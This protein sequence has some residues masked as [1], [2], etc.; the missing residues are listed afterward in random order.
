[1]RAAMRFVTLAALIT[2]VCLTFAPRLF[3]GDQFD[4]SD[5]IPEKY[6]EYW[7]KAQEAVSR[8]EYPEESLPLDVGAE[9][10][11]TEAYQPE[12]YVGFDDPTATTN[13]GES[14][15]DEP[16]TPV[17]LSEVPASAVTDVGKAFDK[18]KNALSKIMRA[19][20]WSAAEA[21][22][23]NAKTCPPEDANYNRQVVHKDAE[24][25]AKVTTKDILAW[26]REMVT[27]VANAKHEGKTSGRGIVMSA[28]DQESFDRVLTN[29]RILRTHGSKLPVEIYH[30]RSE[31][32]ELHLAR[33]KVK[34]LE[35][36][37]AKFIELKGL[38]REESQWK[39]FQI[40]ATA[41]QRC[42]FDQILWLDSDSY[43]LRDPEYLFDSPQFKERGVML[44]PDYTKSHPQQ[45]VWRLLGQPCR[46]EFEA[47]SG[48]VLIDRQRHQDVLFLVEYFAMNW[49][50]FYGFMGGDRESFR[51][52]CLALG[53]KWAGP[54]RMMAMAGVDSPGHPGGHWGLEIA[55]IDLEGPPEN[56]HRGGHTMLQADPEGRWLFAHA[57][58]LK[59]KHLSRANEV[60]WARVT[61]VKDDRYSP[62]T[63]YGDI[64]PA[65]GTAG[66]GSAGAAGSERERENPVDS[67][68]AKLGDGIR[69]YV[70]QGS[71]LEVSMWLLPQFREAD[72]ITEEDWARDPDLRD[73]E[74]LYFEMGG[75][76][77][78]A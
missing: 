51:I 35:S 13:H 12:E 17:G 70:E 16:G 62:G 74:K 32:S 69:S 15:D 22:R 34:E 18:Q 55:G 3:Y 21:A 49:K 29:V 48:Q 28:G 58:L 67:H 72:L 65:A 19:P 5:Q 75:Q 41:M 46:P 26:R 40:K 24:E 27:F 44:W 66:T 39:G 71:E 59:H 20:L 73:F 60:T 9:H 76:R 77:L 1:M 78:N 37:N 33:E 25:W 10:V 47:E 31:K 36:M 7:T 53:V 14:A 42:T 64:A 63:T 54:G 23:R 4:W 30:F 52:A 56:A 57:N 68:N 11:P 38:E 45:P 61:R 43:S 8:G 2:L 6:K 50:N